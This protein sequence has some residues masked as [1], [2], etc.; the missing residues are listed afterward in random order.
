MIYMYY[1]YIYI[2][3]EITKIYVYLYYIGGIG[4]SPDCAT[5]KL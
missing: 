5:S 4:T 3:K 2:L 1:I